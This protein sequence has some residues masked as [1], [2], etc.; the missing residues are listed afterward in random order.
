MKEEGS[1][2]IL[3]HSDDY[4]EMIAYWRLYPDR[5]MDRIRSENAPYDLAPFQRVMLRSFFRYKKVGMVASRGIS[6]CVVGTTLVNTDEGLKR[7][8]DLANWSKEELTDYQ[9]NK[10]LNW[11]GE[12]ENSSIVY[13]NGL[14]DTKKITTKY[15]YEIEGT[16]V[17]PLVV[18][19][20]QG[21]MEFKELQDIKPGD[22]VAMNRKGT[23][24]KN[25]RPYNLDDYRDGKESKTPSFIFS[26]TREVVAEYLSNLFKVK[27]I[28]KANDVVFKTL[29]EQMSIETQL[30][31][32]QL[33]VTAT[34]TKQHDN[35]VD[36]VWE[37][38]ILSKID[39]VTD[40]VIPYQD[41]RLNRLIN[42]NDLETNEIQSDEDFSI[43]MGYKEDN[44][45]WDR[46]VEEEF[47]EDYVYDLYVDDSHT[48]IGNGFVNHN[49]FINVMAHYLKCVLY[50][51]S[52]LGIIMPTKTQSAKVTQE[53]VEEIWRDYPLLE[54]EV[55]KS[56]FAK[57]YTKIKF[58]NGSTLDTITAG[59]SSRGLRANGL[60]FEEIVDEARLD[61]D[62]INEVLLPILAQPRMVSRLGKSPYEHSKTESWVTTA[63]TK[64]S[65]AYEKFNNLLEDMRVSKPSMLLVTSY[66][67]GT[68]F[69]TLD[70][71]DVLGKYSDPSYSPLS[72]D[73]EYRSV[74]TGASERSLIESGV[75]SDLRVLSEPETHAS[76]EDR[77]NRDIK[78][79]LSYDVAR[80]SNSANAN[81]ALSVVKC[82]ARGDGTYQKKL[83]NLFTMEGTHF[84]SQA[85]FL[86]QKVNEFNASVL[87]VDHNG[88]G[89]GLTDELVQEID[90]NPPY[91]V[92]NDDSYDQYKRPNS[93]PM[94]FLFNASSAKTKNVNVINN[95]MT[96]FANHDIQLLKSVA[97][98][99]SE[100][101]DAQ[102]KKFDKEPDAL[103]PFVQ[104]DLLEDE[105]MNLEYVQR[106]N[107]TTIQEISGKIQK[108]RYSAL[109]YALYWIYL[110]E[111]E[112]KKKMGKKKANPARYMNFK[113]PKYKVF[114]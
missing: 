92:L 49:T 9:D 85:K 48:F 4:Y 37:I 66:E 106:G 76:A 54:K 72:F 68:Y 47:S 36:D 13:S 30:L 32:L 67:M 55:Q 79:V 12:I 61:R 1:Q 99:R 93:I 59:E 18:M 7:I 63:G 107:T 87:I 5:F 100:L 10:V 86:K 21:E 112:D 75:M 77:K 2:K 62:T 51:N 38:K 57:D 81:S 113:R 74:F 82:I 80:S 14:Q 41:Q 104:T 26:S 70:E 17:H 101:T 42:N 94:L 31:L 105:I 3:D 73:R 22:Y 50:P 109:A 58:K 91:A 65:F 89:R 90:E 11:N 52:H 88:L 45:F 43:L 16:M 78:Y 71:E 56:Y 6:K 24:G 95:F 15:G 27:D 83:V 33:G 111:T 8:G 60:S 108:D 23:F 19:N 25:D 103:L 98:Y 64:Q 53:K 84:K 40:D 20:K 35:K 46:V 102:R 114:K 44:F 110:Q 29:S 39:N 96:V 69:G 97:G 34:R 28:S